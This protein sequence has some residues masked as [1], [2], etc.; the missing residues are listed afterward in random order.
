MRASDIIHLLRQNY[1][2]DQTCYGSVSMKDSL[3]AK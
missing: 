3:T 1:E 2:G